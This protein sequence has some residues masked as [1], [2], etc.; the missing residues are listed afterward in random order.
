MRRSILHRR[1]GRALAAVAVLTGASIF[2]TA[3]PAEAVDPTY[4]VINYNTAQCADV[5]LGS[6]NQN[7]AVVQEPCAHYSEQ[8]WTVRVFPGD[9]GFELWNYRS[10][11]CLDILAASRDNGA[12]VVQA[13]CTHHTDQQWVY[14]LNHPVGTLPMPGN[15]VYQFINLNSGRCLQ[16]SGG[17]GA[18]LIQ[19]TCNGLSYQQWVVNF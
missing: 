1:L 17:N 7:A 16:V 12:R 15:H 10:D 4:M 13:T 8:L 6:L 9:Q 11:K 5:Y 18:S 19:A 2:G 3:L 14:N